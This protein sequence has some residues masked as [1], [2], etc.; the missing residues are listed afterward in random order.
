VAEVVKITVRLPPNEMEVL[1]R[2]AA[3]E[4]RSL[5]SY[6]RHMALREGAKVGIV[7]SPCRQSA[8]KMT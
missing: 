1:R 7:P 4:S 6:S 8:V 3:S 2:L 5:S